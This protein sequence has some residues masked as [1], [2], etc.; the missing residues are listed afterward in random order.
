MVERMEPNQ[1]FDAEL[2]RCGFI[3][4]EKLGSTYTMGIP[5]M[6]RISAVYSK[7]QVTIAVSETGPKVDTVLIVEHSVPFFDIA[8][9]TNRTIAR[10]LSGEFGFVMLVK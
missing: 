5:E 2:K 7:G 9:A 8:H 1:E 4:D 3:Q 10:F 6:R